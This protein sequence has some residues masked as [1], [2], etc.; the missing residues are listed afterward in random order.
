MDAGYVWVNTLGR[1]YDELPF[2]GVKQ[3]GFGREHGR[4]AL[5]SYTEARTVVQRVPTR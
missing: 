1:V 2:G 5:L 4:D 3:S